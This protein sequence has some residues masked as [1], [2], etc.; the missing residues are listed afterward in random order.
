MQNRTLKMLESTEKYAAFMAEEAQ[1]ETGILPKLTCSFDIILRQFSADGFAAI[2]RMIS[3]S[4]GK[5]R[6]L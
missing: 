4:S 2:D 1:T 6:G 3:N 5:C